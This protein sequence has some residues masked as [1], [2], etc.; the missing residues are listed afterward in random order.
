M[1]RSIFQCAMA[2]LL[3]FV[4]IPA[5][6]ELPPL[7]VQDFPGIISLLLRVAVE[8]GYC[9]KHGIKCIMQKIPNAS[10]GLQALAAGEIDVAGPA[11]E[12][13]IQFAD[14][15]FPLKI[16]GGYL[17]VNNFFLVVGPN[18]FNSVAK[19]YPAMMQDFKGKRIGITARGSSPE[20]QLK[21]LLAD[22]GMK[23]TDVTLVAVGAPPTAYTALVEKQVDAVMTYTPL[24]GFCEALKTCQI[25]VLPAAGQGPKLLTQ[26]NGAGALWVTTREFAKKSATSV[27]AFQNAI[28]DAEKFV[29]VPANEKELLKISRKYYGLDIPQADEVILT[30]IKR[31][32]KNYV[33]DVDKKAVQA[34]ADY[35][36]HTEQISKPFDAGQLF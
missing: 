34:A 32:K 18:L 24:D 27:E 14:K 16:I 13:T 5:K 21:Y 29:Q 33:F 15:G 30:A 28:R 36:L 9:E 25:A 26:M 1:K 3:L 31:F 10:L 12:G 6:A 17:N 22:A 11:A 4:S 8:N 19:G 20:F 7:R 2:S 35:L 23:F